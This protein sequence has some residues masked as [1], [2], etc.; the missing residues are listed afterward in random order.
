VAL[1]WGNEDNR[2]RLLSGF[3][4][5]EAQARAVMST[6][7]REELNFVN[8]AWEYL[9]SFW[10]EVAAKE[11]RLTGIEPEKVDA[12]PF[13]IALTDDSAVDVRG[14][15]YPIKYDPGKVAAGVCPASRADTSGHS[16]GGPAR[17]TGSHPGAL[18][19]LVAGAISS[20]PTVEGCVRFMPPVVAAQMPRRCWCA[21]SERR[22]Y[23]C[24]A[25]W[26]SWRL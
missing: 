22:P 17:C 23:R 20:D 12:A 18:A 10:P 21:S 1:N 7:T 2:Q 5:S 3:G 15:Y 11:K 26:S 19:V 4:W 16:R 9:D 25:C 6:L 14:G 13:S 24:C 8:Q